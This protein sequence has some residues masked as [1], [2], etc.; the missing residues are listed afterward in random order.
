MDLERETVIRALRQAGAKLVD[1]K[2]DLTEANLGKAARILGASRRTLQNRMREYGMPTGTSGRRRRRLPYGS[3]HGSR[4]LG[5]AAL[6]AV[7]LI[8]G[9]RLLRQPRTGA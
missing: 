9:Y 8:L 2:L 1:G 6:G 4:A 7:G 5:A 3:Y